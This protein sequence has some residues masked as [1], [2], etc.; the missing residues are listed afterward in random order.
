VTEGDR[1][2]MRLSLAG[3]HSGSFRGVL[4]TGKPFV[5][6]QMISIHVK[7]GRIA[8]FWED[9]DELGLWYQLGAKLTDPER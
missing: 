6:T 5:L 1:G 4:P 2:A 3:T 7:D 8:E 9:Y